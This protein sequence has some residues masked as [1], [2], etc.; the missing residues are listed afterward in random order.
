MVRR[1]SL[2]IGINY[3]GQ[4][5]ALR[6]C[7][8]D[9]RNMTEFLTARGY[10]SD[11]NSQ[12]ILTDARSGPFYPTGRNILTAMDWLVSEPQTCLFLHYS[13]H[14]SQVRD[15]DGD[16]ASGY[17]STIVPV[18]YQQNGQL[19]SDLLHRHLVSALPP[20]STL[21]VIFDCCHSGSAIELPFVYRT[22]AD[23]NVSLMD[24][25]KTGINLMAQAQQ[26]LGGGFNYNS[27]ND[28]K[29]L[30]AGASSFFSGLTRSREPQGEGF[31]EEHFQEDWRREGKSV[32]MFSGCRDD[33][34][35]ADASIGGSNV[36]AM[37]GF[38]SNYAHPSAA[39]LHP[40]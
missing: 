7:Q 13:G 4:Q 24:N 23:G 9:V 40:S 1:K 38:P 33:Q 25:V 6:G 15:P 31:G 30:L 20:N 37:S 29:S 34:T 27:V 10:P 16:R 2:L 8:Q 14:G 19:N 21:F 36:G 12:V 32:F 22:D 17:D 5:S 18:D 26:L 28:A 11:P 3:T 35:S 39:I